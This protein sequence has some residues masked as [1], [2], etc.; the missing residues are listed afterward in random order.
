[1]IIYG[2]VRIGHA[3]LGK[4]KKRLVLCCVAP[5]GLLHVAELYAKNM[6]LL[7][8]PPLIG[9]LA[10][11][12]VV[13]LV[14][15]LALISSFLSYEW[16]YAA[17]GL[18][19]AWLLGGVLFWLGMSISI[20]A[21]RH[22]AQGRGATFDLAFRQFVGR[23]GHI[24]A[25]ILPLLVLE[26]MFGLLPLLGPLLASLVDLLLVSSLFHVFNGRTIYSSFVDAIGDI[27][28]ILHRDP[29]TLVLMYI[30]M[31]FGVV[32]PVVSF[33][34]FPFVGLYYAYIVKDY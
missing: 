18:F 15:V 8:L 6:G 21:S 11:L 19:G 12:V 16:T 25:V 26:K 33:L 22:L 1:M 30:F 34:V 32:L 27:G 2:R 17:V 24:M 10:G 14:S 4:Q 23:L 28:R 3:K 20:A 13:F 7:V 31:L 29:G 5:S 9:S